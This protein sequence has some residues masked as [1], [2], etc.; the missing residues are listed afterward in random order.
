MYHMLAKMSPEVFPPRLCLKRV[1]CFLP[2]H[3][4]LYYMSK[5]WLLRFFIIMLLTQYVTACK[6]HLRKDTFSGVSSP[7][8]LD[9]TPTQRNM[10]YRQVRRVTWCNTPWPARYAERWCALQLTYARNVLSRSLGY[11]A[12]PSQKSLK[13]SKML[14]NPSC[15]HKG[16]WTVS[17]QWYGLGFFFISSL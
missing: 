7:H 11:N 9:L 6:V 14:S 13:R 1:S 5:L 17:N 2:L 4:I 3:D 16:R 12:A 15:D 10:F 8:L